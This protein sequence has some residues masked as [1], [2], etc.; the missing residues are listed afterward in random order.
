ME[1]ST[2]VSVLVTA[3][4]SVPAVSQSGTGRKMKG[5]EYSN[6]KNN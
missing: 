2:S 1:Y 5:T 3:A 4:G 6:A